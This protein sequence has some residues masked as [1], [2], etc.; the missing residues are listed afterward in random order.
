MQPTLG[1]IR[2]GVPER[3]DLAHI[4]NHAR[5]HILAMNATINWRAICLFHYGLMGTIVYG[6]AAIYE[7]GGQV[8][9]SLAHVS[10]LRI[11]EVQ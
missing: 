4:G 7:W 1:Y 3:S 2:T 8:N 6:N 9:R 5:F 10:N 11:A